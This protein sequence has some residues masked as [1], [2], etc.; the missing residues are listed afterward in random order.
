MTVYVAMDHDGRIFAICPTREAARAYSLSGAGQ[1][2]GA[3]RVGA[4]QVA[5]SGGDLHSV[6]VWRGGKWEGEAR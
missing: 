6:E 5:D 3:F 4:W 2:A 1:S